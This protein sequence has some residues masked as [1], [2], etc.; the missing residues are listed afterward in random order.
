MELIADKQA[1]AASVKAIMAFRFLSDAE[2][3]D[4]LGVAELATYEEGEPVV[5]EGEISPHFFGILEGTVGVTVREPEG[6]QVYVNSLGAGDMFGEAGIFTSVPRTATVSALA[7]AT[8]LR[9]H[10][11][12]LAAFLERHPA[13]GNKILLV[14]IYGLL[15]KLKLVNRE[16]AYERKSDMKQE[17]VDAMVESLFGEKG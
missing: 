1:R 17:D 3:A 4:L 7:P 8:I 14:I 2:T 12:E 9:L 15:R 11:R 10:R 5:E 16:L 6:G 13:A